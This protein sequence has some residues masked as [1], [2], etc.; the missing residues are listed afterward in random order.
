MTASPQQNHASPWH[1]DRRV[2]LALI[3][4]LLIQ[5]AS[6]LIWAGRA[7]QRISHIEER[8]VLIHAV[9]ERIAR[10]EAQSAYMTSAITRIERKIDAVRLNPRQKSAP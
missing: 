5:G 4:A 10:L 9:S 6:G 3:I 1:L 7:A 8:A 2:P